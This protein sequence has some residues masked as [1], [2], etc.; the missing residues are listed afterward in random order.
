MDQPKPATKD[1][2]ASKPTHLLDPDRTCPSNFNRQSGP[3]ARA[4]QKTVL[5]I[6]IFKMDQRTTTKNVARKEPSLHQTTEKDL[7]LQSC[8]TAVKTT[9]TQQH[10]AKAGPSNIRFTEV[11]PTKSVRQSRSTRPVLRRLA[12]E[13]ESKK[14]PGLVEKKKPKTK[15][16]NWQSLK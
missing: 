8:A 1:A 11:G 10:S 15:R 14:D 7:I 13:V 9:Q 6:P 12:V 3:P 2:C 4:S 5:S 16:S